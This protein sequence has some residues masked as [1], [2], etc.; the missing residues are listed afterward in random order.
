MEKLNFLTRDPKVLTLHNVG[1]TTWT[2]THISSEE[3]EEEEEDYSLQEPQIVKILTD[4]KPIPTR[5]SASIVYTDDDSVN[6]PENAAVDAYFKARKKYKAPKYK[7]LRPLKPTAKHPVYNKH[8]SLT[9]QRF[10][11]A[12][13]LSQLDLA[14]AVDFQK[15][16]TLSNNKTPQFQRNLVCN[17]STHK[18]ND[19]ENSSNSNAYYE[20]EKNRMSRSLNFLN[21]PYEFNPNEINELLNQASTYINKNTFSLTQPLNGESDDE[22][23][24]EDLF[25]DDDDITSRVNTSSKSRITDELPTPQHSFYGFN[26][27]NSTHD[28]NSLQTLQTSPIHPRPPRPSETFS[29]R[30]KYGTFDLLENPIIAIK[31]ETAESEVMQLRSNLNIRETEFVEKFNDEKAKMASRMEAEKER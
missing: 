29:K 20:N 10:I 14:Q 2:P 22:D 21:E 16:K 24:N 31:L 25:N 13:L 1:E 23:D 9:Q 17:N 7:E 4:F 6:T 27:T 3:N 8:K 26:S 5:S 18:Y 19:F 30:D 15:D 28:K 11:E 12:S